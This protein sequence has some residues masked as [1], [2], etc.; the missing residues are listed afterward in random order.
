M[1]PRW[2]IRGIVLSAGWLALMSL[3]GCQPSTKPAVAAPAK[4]ASPSKVEGAVK[5]ADLATVKLTPEAE[6]RLGIALVAVERKPVPRTS[7][8]GGEVIIPPGRL[9]SVSSPFIGTLK[10]PPGSGIP[11]P[12]QTVK[13]GQTVFVLVPILSP[14]ARATMAPLLIEAEGQV[15]QAQEQ[16]N[17]A[18]VQLDRAENLFRDRQVGNA[19]VVDAKANYDL[20][21]TNLKNAENRREILAK[22]GADAETGEMH[23]Q[24]IAAPASG[25]LQ[26]VHA[27]TGQKVAAGALLLDVAS[28]DPIWVK[29]PVYVGDLDRIAT[30]K[31]AGVGGLAD[32]P[33][34]ANRIAR[35][36]DAPPSADP[37]AATANLF[38]EVSNKDATLRPG[39]RVGVTLPLKGED[40]SL[41]VPRAALLRDIH[42]DT[43]VY[44][45]TSPHTF[46]RRRVSVDRVVGDLAAIATGPKPG[47][48]IVTDGAAEL[49]GTEFGGSK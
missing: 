3:A 15:K 28:L 34:A 32:A 40:Q 1:N 31:D 23:A 10:D 37:L 30:D 38:Y 43:W 48:K 14:E 18:K 25:T 20:A 2:W 4:T 7:T 9:I 47:A 27:R 19:A 46:A 33:G 13:E 49:F 6:K 41:V 17:I 39:Q 26:N 44:E 5:E 42:G 45:N 36:V 35:P 12:G 16:L 24:K 22:V 8:Y 21:K 29:V 11:M